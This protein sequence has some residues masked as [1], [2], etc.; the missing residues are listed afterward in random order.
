VVIKYISKQFGFDFVLGIM[1]I[2]NLHFE[3]NLTA[4]KEFKKATIMP[5][6][7]KK[8]GNLAILLAVGTL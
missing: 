1:L 4:I 5:S 7:N 8:I 3:S 2:F 6:G